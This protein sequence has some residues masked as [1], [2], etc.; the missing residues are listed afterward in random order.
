MKNVT[1]IV[2]ELG[3]VGIAED[4]IGI[5]DVFFEEDEQPKNLYECL[6]PLLQ[7]AARQLTEYFAGTRKEFA[8]PLSIQGTE[9]QLADWKALQTIPYGETR[10][11]G[12]I[13]TQIG[14]PKASRAVGMANHK[15]PI[16]I[17]IPCHRVIG[18]NGKLVGYG[19]GLDKKEKLLR[20]E[21]NL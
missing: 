21:G 18:H 11:Y 7:E 4:G 16:S 12:Q 19:G 15:N 9:F 5:T 17:I 14:N 10:S 6:T 2:T 8:L 3:R 20:L 1:Y 13:A